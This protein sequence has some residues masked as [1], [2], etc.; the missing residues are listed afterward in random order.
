MRADLV[1]I[2]EQEKKTVLFVT[3]DIDEAVQL[4]DRVVVFSRRPASVRD[5]VPV[6]LPRPRDPSAPGYLRTRDH[7][8]GAVGVGLGDAPEPGDG[9][10]VTPAAGAADGTPARGTA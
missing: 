3:H 2:W 10:A 7:I 8:L 4:A 1:R 5:V 9:A 6:D